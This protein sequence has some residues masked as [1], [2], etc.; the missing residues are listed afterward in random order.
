[1][2]DSQTGK[3][4]KLF[5]DR[6]RLIRE[7][8]LEP[9]QKHFLH[10][11]ADCVRWNEWA[12]PTQKTL[13]LD[14]GVTVTRIQ[15]VIDELS[16]L[17]VVEERSREENRRYHEYR[18]DF[19]QLAAIQQTRDRK[20][21]QAKPASPVVTDSDTKP[22]SSTHTK[23]AMSSHTKPAWYRKNQEKE[24]RES[25]PSKGDG[26]EWGGIE[27]QL[28]AEGV[29]EERKAVRQ[30]REAGCSPADIQAVIDYFRSRRDAWELP[31]AALYRR[32]LNATPDRRAD[33]PATWMPFSPAF[34]RRE[35]SIKEA[36]QRDAEREQQRLA[37]VARNQANQ[38]H[39]AE[40]QRLEDQF[41]AECDR[42]TPD[43]VRQIAT[44]DS[45]LAMP[46]RLAKSD[47]ASPVTSSPTLRPYL[48]RH[49]AARSPPASTAPTEQTPHVNEASARGTSLSTHHVPSKEPM[50]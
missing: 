11:L 17:R 46:Y 3:W 20:H 5:F 32:V 25:S 8:K 37:G 49:L 2:P 29:R 21:R 48:L 44:Q 34:V 33:D 4:C 28:R 13:A 35:Q 47:R 18:I 30:A 12:W 26:D 19:G 50:T 16:V 22:A 43:D 14:V 31:E 41:G 27:K 7:A 45:S 40:L 23:S 9:H 36:H 10:V 39:A 15:Q 24:P 1:M 6:K 42:L 38:R